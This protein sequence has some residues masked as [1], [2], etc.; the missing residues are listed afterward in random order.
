MS[1]PQ[2]CSLENGVLMEIILFL[3]FCF[4]C[5]VIS[6]GLYFEKKKNTVYLP[7]IIYL[8]KFKVIVGENSL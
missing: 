3:F 4:N 1:K 8:I 2:H 5:F 6:E 7:E